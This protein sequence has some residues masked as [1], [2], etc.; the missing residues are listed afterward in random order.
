MGF[1]GSSTSPPLPS[2]ID[3]LTLFRRKQICCWAGSKDKA[4]QKAMVESAYDSPGRRQQL[5]ESLAGK[6]DR[7]AVSSRLLADKHQGTPPSAAVTQKPSLAKQSNWRRTVDMAR[8]WDAADLNSR[9]DL[10]SVLV[11]CAHE[12]ATRTGRAAGSRS[13]PGIALLVRLSTRGFPLFLGPGSSLWPYFLRRTAGGS[14][15]GLES[16]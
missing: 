15:Q 5:A 2:P 13:F 6:G 16:S 1:T 4:A 12:V 3:S 10:G 11:C 9:R 7:E 14:R 8:H